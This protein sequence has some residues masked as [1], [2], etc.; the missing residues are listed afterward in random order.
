MQIQDRLGAYPCCEVA[1]IEPELVARACQKIEEREA[2]LT[3]HLIHEPIQ[4]LGVGRPGLGD[5]AQAWQRPQF[6]RLLV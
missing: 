4:L 2:R 1:T 3:R 6:F 5:H